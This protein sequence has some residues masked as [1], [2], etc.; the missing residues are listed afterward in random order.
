M[1]YKILK[2]GQKYNILKTKGAQMTD[3]TNDIKQLMETIDSKWKNFNIMVL[4]LTGSGKSTL[5]NSVFG[6]NVA[7]VGAGRPITKEITCYKNGS[8]CLYDTEGIEVDGDQQERIINDICNTIHSCSHQGIENHIHMIWYCIDAT[9]R[10][11][12]IELTLLKR[13]AQCIKEAKKDIAI[14]FIITKPAL[15][16]ENDYNI[17]YNCLY[18]SVSQIF[19]KYKN[20]IV[21]VQAIPTTVGRG[22]HKVILEAYGLDDLD[23]CVR[24]LLPETIRDTY[25]THQR[26]NLQSKLD[27][28]NKI[29]ITHYATTGAAIAGGATVTGIDDTWALIGM[30]IAMFAE[31][32]NIFHF[33]FDENKIRAAIAGSIGVGVASAVGKTIF[34]YALAA[35]TGGLSL[36]AEAVTRITIA[37]SVTVSVGKAYIKL[38]EKFATGEMSEDQVVLEIESL[39]KKN[40]KQK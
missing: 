28:A 4:G 17:I 40:H 6:K 24:R 13:V 35:A 32:G 18:E 5:I 22:N 7:A 21:E 11:Q 9:S 33:S 23:N 15:V 14:V 10:I 2:R 36:A 16:C 12:D 31:I 29:L 19:P 25:D 3:Y 38:M 39:L 26:I 27:K 1:I 30:Q 8:L 34:H 37:D 20:N